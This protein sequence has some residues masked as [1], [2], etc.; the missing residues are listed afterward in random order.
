MAEAKNSFIKSRMNK[1]LDERLIPNNEYRDALNIAVSRSEGSDVGAVE[2]ILGNSSTA[3]RPD[4]GHHIIGFYSDEANNKLYYFRTN[5]VKPKQNAPLSAICTIGYLNTLNNTNVV[6]VEGSF[7]NFCSE[8]FVNGISLI[9]NQLFFTDNRNQPRKINVE[10]KLGYYT[11]EDQ[12][13]VAKFAPYTPPSF[14]NLRAG[15]SYYANFTNTTKPSTMSDAQDPP[16][17]Q[18]GIYKLS[19]NNLSVKKYRNGDVIPESTTLSDWNQKNTN[20]IGSWCYYANYNGNGI[21]YGLLYNKWAIIDARGLAPVGHTIP[22]LAD[23][24]GIIS[25]GTTNANLYKST[26]LWSS[27]PGSNQ[28]GSDVLPAG[29]RDVQYTSSDGFIN[30]TAESRFWTSDAISNSSAPYVKFDTTATIDVSS[31]SSTVN[32]YSVRV[33]RD[34]NYT[35]WNGDPDYLSDKFVKFSYRF[36]FDDNEYS[37]VAPFSQDVFIPYQE[38]E[39]V[40][41]D[42]NQAFISSVVE[43]MQNSINNAVLNIE[44][45]CIDIINKYKVKA[46]DI[47]I[48]QSDMQAYQVIET[49]KVDSNFISNLNNTNIYQYS[50]ESTIPIQTLPDSQSTRVF[51][52]VPVKA[53]AQES[54]GN[55]IMYSN[56]L[57]SHSAPNGLDYYV[58]IGNKSLQ[59][60]VE[61]PQHSLKQNRNYQV[62][63]ILVDKYG[64]QTDVILSNYDGVLDE[65]GNPQPGSNYYS[66]YKPVSW[67]SL[68]LPTWPGDTLELKYLQPIPEGDIGIN[69]Y[70]GAYAVGNYYEVDTETA[71]SPSALYAYFH[72]IGTQ[73]IIPTALQTVFNTAIVYADATASSNTFNVYV[74]SG[75]GWIL[76]NPSTT[77]P[78]YTVLDNSG[79]VRV[80][81]NSG[82]AV[83]Q[84]VKFEV[85]YTNDKYYKY[86]TGAGSSTTRPLF[87]NFPAQYSKYY[88]VGKKLKGLYIDYTEVSSVTPIT[89]SNGVRAV[90]F[91]TKQEV[92]TNYL[93]NET[94]AARPEPSK[95]DQ[96]NTYAT[97]DI[98]VLGFYIYKS[99]VKQQQQDYYNVYLPGIVNGYPISGETLEQGEIAFTTLI[100]DNINKVPRNLQDVGP[101][102]EQFTSDV[103]MW[104][105][106]TN[107]TEVESSTITYSTFNKQV[108]P[109]ASA[110][111]VD[112]VG[113]LKDI[114]PGLVSDVLPPAIET[115]KVN[116][117]SIYNFST[118]PFVAKIA[119]QKSVGLGESAYTAPSTTNGNYPYSPDMGLAVYE[120]SPYVSPLELFYESSTADLISSLNLDIENENTNITGISA[121]TYVFEESFALGTQVTSDFFPVASG[122]NLV[123]TT[124]SPSIPFTC[125]SYFPQNSGASAGLLDTNTPQDG[126][127]VLE[128]GTQ[129]GS[130]RI[131]TNDRFYAGS[132]TEN[133]DVTNRGRFLFTINFVQFDGT[134]VSQQLTL[135][136]ANSAPVCAP[137]IVSPTITQ[138]TQTLVDFTSSNGGRNGS[139]RNVNLNDSTPVGTT[140]GSANLTSGWTIDRI[141]KTAATTGNVQV[142][143][144]TSTPNTINSVVQTYQ[145]TDD[146]PTAQDGQIT[147]IGPSDD[148]ANF[149]IQAQ[150]DVNGNMPGFMNEAGF[151]YEIYM[152]LTD[153]L[154]AQST[155]IGGANSAKIEYSVGAATFIGKVIILPY[156]NNDATSSLTGDGI[157]VNNGGS[158]AARVNRYQIQNWTDQDVY[159]YIQ[160][161]V[162]SSLIADN[163][164][165]T[166]QS[167]SSTG[168]YGNNTI[169]ITASTANGYPY[170][171]QAS[172]YVINAN[173]Q[174]SSETSHTNGLGSSAGPI[175]RLQCI[176]LQR[177]NK[178]GITTPGLTINER[179]IGFQDI[180]QG[181]VR[182][183]QKS[184]VQNNLYKYDFSACAVVNFPISMIPGNNANTTGSFSLSWSHSPGQTTPSSPVNQLTYVNNVSPPFY[185]NT[186]G[187]APGYP[188][189]VPVPVGPS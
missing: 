35:G 76:Q 117:F 77:P 167:P 2:S 16:I 28:I 134:E 12:I 122:T 146:F 153:T 120:T 65:N 55:R 115:G 15:A 93:F 128:T 119:T 27:G 25:A 59:Q 136:L 53:L 30:L 23:W 39:F 149:K 24:N 70:P 125:F 36:K 163:T 52:K 123:D 155:Q 184:T 126:R 173:T 63:I 43:F 148:Q 107:I 174:A 161:A 86:E 179:N 124:L 79:S 166:T 156:N 49:V 169:N 46:I 98:N 95:F 96:K 37:T 187:V 84:V 5:H 159:I 58:G 127:F 26:D 118:K 54:T 147:A 131:R 183:G 20:E 18:I 11:N 164:S 17:V 143:T 44:L 186:T 50:Y 73:C 7:L 113:G 165:V 102:Q 19:Q 91:F 137:T 81:F 78:T 110:D 66:D 172:T 101:N 175:S 154:G 157:T 40:N 42:E 3:V 132:S 90:T 151:S 104:P 85:L 21:T 170:F 138:S 108:D 9:E 48:K 178:Q 144:T 177:F 22:S 182:P 57:E 152:N 121:F 10:Q 69:G 74:D 45:P 88:S 114:F 94:P 130:Y 176:K 29:F 4:S 139:A 100:S 31:T 112:L 68:Q 80:T 51:D 168:K 105:R 89:D 158:S 135:Q 133:E 14:I 41:D 67:S 60:F 185:T 56:Y 106:V 160:A 111:Q 188:T 71:S 47:I 62:G 171:S 64:R 61:Y 97:Y 180:I 181:G 13:S 83:N 103:T 72:S 109:E 8:D 32:G 145:S 75:N 162:A 142:I 99:A 189:V 82:L 34:E 141:T 33:L 1:D 116:P 87:P 38:G 150:T 92:D 6:L 140:F 129:S